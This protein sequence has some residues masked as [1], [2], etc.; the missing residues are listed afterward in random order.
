MIQNLFKRS[1][2]AKVSLVTLALLMVVLASLFYYLT[3]NE[4]SSNNK[5]MEVTAS[6]TAQ[7]VMEKVD[8]NFY[9]RFGDV[10]AFAFNRLA[11][12]TVEQDS[13]APGIQQFINT[14]TAYYVLYDLMMLCDR[15]GKVLAVNTQNKF[16]K[17]VNSGFMLNLNMSEESWFKV[18]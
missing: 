16:G 18:C 8:R 7:S 15:D 4:V 11:V 10:Q 2:F 5:S 3:H 17:A 1:A 6:L 9:E 12:Q 14:M 13:L